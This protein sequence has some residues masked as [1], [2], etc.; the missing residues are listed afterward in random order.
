M[1]LVCGKTT[2]VHMFCSVLSF[3]FTVKLK[4]HSFIS[5]FKFD[6]FVLI[7]IYSDLIYLLIINCRWITK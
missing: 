1:D 7:L 6:L 2:K 4:F 3:Y 5:C